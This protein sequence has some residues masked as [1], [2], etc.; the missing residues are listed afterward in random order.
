MHASTAQAG[1]VLVEFAF[2]AFAFYLLFAGTIELGRMITVSQAIQN[3]ARVGARELALVPL[4]PTM[5]FE[6]AIYPT[7]EPLTPDQQKVRDRIFDPFKLAVD[8]SAG[9]PNVDAWPIINRMLYPVM[10]RSRVGT[11]DFLHFPGAILQVPGNRY[12]VG[13][14][15]VVSRDPTGVETIRWLRVV[16][17]VRSNPSDLNSGPFSLAS[18]GPE[19]GLV[20]LRINCPYQATTMTAFRVEGG[21]P[22]MTPI[23]AHDGAVTAVNAAPENGSAVAITPP[24]SGEA[25]NNSTGWFNSGP[26]GLGSME[27]MGKQVRPFRR[28]ISSQSLFR[29]E[30]FAQ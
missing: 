24:P 18:S 7:V 10:I 9:E 23:E 2:I 1:S 27:A 16:E 14:P 17:E 3:A 25:G 11:Q 26:Y 8:V 22:S 15:K 6:E 19:R 13:V 20:A 29:R 21:G 28:L 30:V 12:T 5:T 4:P